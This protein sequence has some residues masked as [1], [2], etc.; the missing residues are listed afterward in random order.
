M[1]QIFQKRILLSKNS[2]HEHH[3]WILHI[4]IR[5]KIQFKL[6]I[7][8]FLDQIF[9]KIASSP[10]NRKCEHG[11]W[12]LH[13]LISYVPHFSLNWQF[14]FF[15]PNSLQKG[16]SSQKQ[17]KWTIKFCIFELV[18]IANFSLNWRFWFFRS[19]FSKKVFPI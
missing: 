10:Q 19:N 14:W 8:F 13:I 2:K 6:A 5:T 3:H 15:W 17:K 9:A 1:Q 18:K 4:R 11:H 16:I 12:I 7:F